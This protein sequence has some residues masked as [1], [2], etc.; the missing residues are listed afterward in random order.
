MVGM[1]AVSAFFLG[2]AIVGGWI[3]GAVVLGRINQTGRWQFGLRDMFLIL[4]WA[5]LLLGTIA[6][7]FQAFEIDDRPAIF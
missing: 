5:S 7:V 1:N 3:L 6:T 4:L 2:F